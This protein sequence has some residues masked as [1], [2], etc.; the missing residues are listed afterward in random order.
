MATHSIRNLRLVLLLAIGLTGVAT[1]GV[2]L[3][4]H[5]VLLQEQGRRQPLE[6]LPETL[7]Q[8]AS[9]FRMSHSE[10]SRTTFQATAKKAIE[11]KEGGKSHLED[12]DIDI[13]GKNGDR[14]DHITSKACEYDANSGQFY[15]EGRVFI[16]LSSM[17]GAVTANSAN[18]P[19]ASRSPNSRDAPADTQPPQGSQPVDLET[20]GFLYDQKK[21]IA[22]TER[23]LVFQFRNGD[24]AGTGAVY[25]SGQQTLWLKQD[26]I[27]HLR[28]GH[29]VDIHAAELRY[30]QRERQIQFVKPV[31]IR[32]DETVS[33]TIT[34]DRGTLYLDDKQQVN[35]VL[36]E[37][38]IH[39]VADSGSGGALRLGGAGKGRHSEV[40]ANRMD[41]GLDEKQHV[42]FVLAIGD[43]RLDSHG[44]TG[45]SQAQ[46]P[47]LEMDMT[48]PNNTLKQA[49]WKEGAKLTFSPL[50]TA[51]R[52]QTRVITAEQI[53]MNMK[54][55]GKELSSARTLTPGRVEMTGGGE[56]RRVLTARQITARFGDR[57]A[58]REMHAQGQVRTD[59]DP[60]ANAKPGPGG[61]PPAQRI[62]TS[63]RLDATFNA[64][65]QLD[66]MIQSGSFQYHEGDRH[67]TAEQAVYTVTPGTNPQTGTTVL[68]GPATKPNVDP[69]VWDLNGRVI[70]RQIT[71]PDKGETLAEGEVRATQLP[72][73]DDKKNSKHSAIFGGT[74][75]N[76]K[77]KG[78]D[79]DPVHALTNRL[80]WD[81]QTG[82]SHYDGGPNGKVR[83]WQGQDF[84]EALSVDMDR[85]GKRL[86]AVGEVYSYL[87]EDGKDPLRVQS[88]RLNYNDEQRHARYEGNVVMHSQDMTTTAFTVD[89][90]LRDPDHLAPGESRLEKA[91]ADGKVHYSQP[92][93][94]AAAGKKAHAGRR[95]ESD[96]GVY[97]SDDDKIVLTGGP[98]IV[99]DEVRGITTGRELTW[100]TSDDKIFVD[101]GPDMR[102]LSQHR[103]AKKQPQ[104]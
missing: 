11:N 24:G 39:G 73:K 101:G 47:R 49:L 74:K 77:D 84:L 30:M 104:P 41:M 6:R 55:D 66:S 15:S 76:E 38:N 35:H 81:R 94:A 33:Q 72:S 3:A 40:W 63:D 48:G 29:P 4:K 9:V 42:Q 80:R 88:E 92:A 75:K 68:T 65:Q 18:A 37:N 14:H 36:L 25:D 27:I 10:G 78:Q 60:P 86:I 17:P 2:Y 34:G 62:T 97:T 90:W 28:R 100:L 52:G 31:M 64:Q 69:V 99:R 26:V 79:D 83:I 53:E 1:L 7:N 16:H 20:S 67:A 51:A 58:M 70:A 87:V 8:K 102:T 56:P 93:A 71:M 45:R 46:A 21:N 12:V 61:E 13:Y 82:L 59:S 50:P 85:T 5:R 23:D 89:A 91:I 32:K 103:M 43:V 98:P 54:E 96:H 95:S 57:S 22:T 19:D 44:P